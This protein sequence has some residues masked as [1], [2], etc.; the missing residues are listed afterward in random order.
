[1]GLIPDQIPV[2][3]VEKLI[4]VRLLKCYKLRVEIP[5]LLFYQFFKATH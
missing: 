5:N 3:K 4:D 2:Y 1:M